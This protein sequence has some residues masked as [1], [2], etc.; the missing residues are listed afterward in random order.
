M[1]VL[2]RREGAA[3]VREIPGL[4]TLS[5]EDE[6]VLAIEVYE[7]SSIA[8]EGWGA[9][10]LDWIEMSAIALSLNHEDDIVVIVLSR[11]YITDSRTE[12]AWFGLTDEGELATIRI[13][14]AQAA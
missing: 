8:G 12:H 5:L 4:V 2:L 3:S 1:G 14:S 9:W 7:F 6:I 10:D 11:G 13:E